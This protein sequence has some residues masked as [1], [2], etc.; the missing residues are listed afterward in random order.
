MKFNGD[1]GGLAQYQWGPE[2]S[3]PGAW[4]WARSVNTSIFSSEG[5][6]FYR[7]G[8]DWLRGKHETEPTW[9]QFEEK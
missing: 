2:Y 8:S 4:N 1:S 7:S 3:N 5:Q 6:Q 9:K